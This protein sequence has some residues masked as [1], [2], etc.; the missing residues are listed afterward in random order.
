MESYWGVLTVLG[1]T[2]ATTTSPPPQQELSYEEAVSLA[3]NLY[4]QGPQVAFAFRLLEA[5]PQPD[6]A[7]INESLQLLPFTVKETKCPISE[8]LLLDKCDFRAN[9]VVTECSGTLSV[10]QEAPLVLLT[11]NT[12]TQER[13]Q[14]WH[15]RCGKIRRGIKEGIKILLSGRGQGPLRRGVPGTI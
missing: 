7:T 10:D 9:G 4:D 8:D 13:T 5:E 1:V 15:S 6:G 14:A 12:V 3:I 11:C 2:M